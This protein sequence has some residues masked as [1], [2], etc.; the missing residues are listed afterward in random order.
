M[1]V[2][3]VLLHSLENQWSNNIESDDSEDDDILPTEEYWAI[4]DEGWTLVEPHAKSR[5]VRFGQNTSYD[6]LDDIVDNT[7]LLNYQKKVIRKTS[8]LVEVSSDARTV[9]VHVKSA[10][11]KQPDRVIVSP[12][13][14]VKPTVSDQPD[15]FI[16][17]PI[18]NTGGRN[19]CLE[20]MGQ[21]VKNE[22]T[23]PTVSTELVNLP[24][25]WITRGF[26][27]LAEEARLVDVR[28]TPS[29]CMNRVV[30]QNKMA[31]EVII[32]ECPVGQ[33]V[34]NETTK[35]TVSTEL[36]N[37]PQEWITG[38]FLE[39]AEE[40][41]LVDV[42][43]TPSG[44]MKE[45]V[46]RSS[47]IREPMSRDV[48]W[49]IE[50]VVDRSVDS[51]SDVAIRM[52]TVRFDEGQLMQWPSGKS[53]GMMICEYTLESQMFSHGPVWRE[54]EPVFVAAESEVF[55]PVFTGEFV[56]QTDPLV[57]TEAVTPRVSALPTVGSEFQTGLSTS[58]GYAQFRWRICCFSV[59][60][61]L[62]CPLCYGR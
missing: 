60:F 53:T 16:G 48:S 40:A 17:S 51:F 62:L 18:V 52:P 4:P 2:T 34:K 24:K 25:E 28:S 47:E 19:D 8:A 59:Q 21:V 31:E 23:K 38:G 35:P 29:G 42:R 61:I 15:R 43:S 49:S 50:E 46:Q 30:V 20:R 22:T 37:L 58:V 1:G 12:M 45:D 14:D 33:V 57:V 55:T 13:D 56:E 3:S 39:L 5:G 9:S 7:V 41:R 11:N 10:V 44:C 32:V 36:V 6:A 27:E 54:A 26:L